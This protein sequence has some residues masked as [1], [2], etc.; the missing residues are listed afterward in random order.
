[1]KQK[2]I[3]KFSFYDRIFFLDE[4]ISFHSEERCEPS[5]PIYRNQGTQ[6][7]CPDL[8]TW[9]AFVNYEIGDGLDT[10]DALKPN[11]KLPKLPKLPSADE[12][13]NRVYHKITGLKKRAVASDDQ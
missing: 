9:D 10:F 7:N 5:N 13:S 4:F 11:I 8:A 1:M 6:R 2:K 12:V 3:S